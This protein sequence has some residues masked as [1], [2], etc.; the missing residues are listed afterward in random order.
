MMGNGT[1][2]CLK[3][4][5]LRKELRRLDGDLIVRFRDG[6]VKYPGIYLMREDRTDHVD[7]G[8]PYPVRDRIAEI[9]RA[10][11]KADRRP[12]PPKPKVWV[13][14]R[15]YELE[16]NA[17]QTE[18]CDTFVF[19]NRTNAVRK[20]ASLLRADIKTHGQGFAQSDVRIEEKVML[21]NFRTKFPRHLVQLSFGDS[22]VYEL[23]RKGVR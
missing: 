18:C 22:V 13:L 14:I 16:D 5:G 11:R 10:V 9:D 20:A 6:D 12:P 15:R 23:C 17:Q 21:A 19:T 2:R 7:I 3:V 4:D 8:L 1:T